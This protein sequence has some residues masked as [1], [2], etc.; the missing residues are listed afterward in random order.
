MTFQDTSSACSFY[1]KGVDQLVLLPYSLGKFTL[2]ALYGWHQRIRKVQSIKLPVHLTFVIIF[3]AIW[4]QSFYFLE[5]RF[6]IMNILSTFC[7]LRLDRRSD[8]ASAAASNS[9]SCW[10]HLQ[11]RLSFFSTN[12]DSLGIIF[13]SKTGVIPVN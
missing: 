10:W 5:V 11:S 12:N 2:R 13:P 7:L 6:L 8:R 3:L 9:S 1:N 4:F